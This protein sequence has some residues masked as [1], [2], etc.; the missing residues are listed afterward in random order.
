MDRHT[1]PQREK[2]GTFYGDDVYDHCTARAVLYGMPF[3]VLDERFTLISALEALDMSEP[4]SLIETWKQDF[5]SA[6]DC[7]DRLD[8]LTHARNLPKGWQGLMVE[9]D[10]DDDDQEAMLTMPLEGEDLATGQLPISQI[11]DVYSLD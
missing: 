11:A 10:V 7:G 8:Q 3:D 5:N 2:Q 4:E 1:T 6:A 9:S